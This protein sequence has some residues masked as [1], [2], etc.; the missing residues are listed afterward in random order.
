VKE[1]LQR[2]HYSRDLC[3]AEF[4][5]EKHGG[6]MHGG[7]DLHALERLLVDTQ[8]V[9]DAP[10]ILDKVVARGGKRVAHARFFVGIMNYKIATQIAPNGDDVITLATIRA[11]NVHAEHLH[12]KL[13]R[14]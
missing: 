10:E 6:R 13:D 3:S 5:Y 14:V 1:L 8:K 12:K 11:K 7:Q 9:K 2:A 4:L